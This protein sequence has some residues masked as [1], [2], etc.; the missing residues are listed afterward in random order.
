MNK[1]MRWVCAGCLLAL[2][3][4][5]TSALARTPKPHAFVVKADTKATFDP[6]AAQ[7]RDEMVAGG[8]FE[9]VSRKEFGQVDQAL[10]D[11]SLLFDKYGSVAAMDRNTQIRLLNDQ[12]LVNGV[13]RRRDGERLICENTA[14]TGSHIPSMSC[15]SYAELERNRNDTQQFL[16]KMKQVNNPS[17]KL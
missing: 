3:P 16:Q 11:M 7:V 2:V 12:E 4:Y 8:R 13:L 17:N 15:T 1:A 9:F 6:L 5:G 14:P 10:R